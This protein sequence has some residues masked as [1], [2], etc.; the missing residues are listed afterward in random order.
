MCAS[1]II[2]NVIRVIHYPHT[3][4]NAELGYKCMLCIFV[5]V[6]IRMFNTS[7]FAIIFHEAV[8]LSLPVNSRHGGLYFSAVRFLHLFV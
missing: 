3:N 2:L 5:N 4:A 7:F 6:S 1:S 8:F